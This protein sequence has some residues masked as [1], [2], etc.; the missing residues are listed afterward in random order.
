VTVQIHGERSSPGLDRQ[1]Q[2]LRIETIGRKSGKRHHV[3]LR[4]ITIGEKI[5]VFPQNQG[6]Q[7]WVSNLRAN[8]KVKLYTESGI[9]TCNA[10]T[11]RINGTDDPILMVFTRK[12]GREVVNQRYK[13]QRTYVELDCTEAETGNLDDLVYDDLQAAFDGIAEHYDRHI[14]GNPINTWLRNVSVDLLQQ[15]FRPGS[16]VLEIGCGTGTETLQ[17]ARHGVKVLAC[18]I[19]GRMLEVLKR[20]AKLEGLD[21][22]VFTLHCRADG[23]KKGVYSS[24]FDKFDGAYSTYG[25]INTEPRLDDLFRDL[26]DLL[27]ED[28]ILVLGV[29]N[30]YCL[31]ETLGYMLRGK[32][33]LAFAR[34][35]NPVPIGRSRFC[36]ASN[37]YSTASLG[38][39]VASFFKLKSIL[40]V[41]II[42]PPSNLTRYLP[43]GRWLTFFKRLDLRL[44]RI[45]PFNHLGDHFLAVYTA[46]GET[47][48]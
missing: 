3:L 48:N 1:T 46:R 22:R 43:R 10:E 34:L 44:G 4:F 40:G 7:D 42:L 28:G 19:S 6:K 15:V 41:V 21:D 13:G 31:Y 47:Q 11:R 27:K 33:S 36:V 35:R 29:W 18:D 39:H 5:L 45:F 17:L 26:H 2:Y 24:G 20:K 16:T 25:A 8:P 14:L 37:A 30:K 12:Y 23:L 32:P 9:F 38:K